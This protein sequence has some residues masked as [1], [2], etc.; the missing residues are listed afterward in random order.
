MK[1][2]ENIKN[3]RKALGMMQ[4]DVAELV[5][6]TQ[7]LICEIERG[8]KNPSFTVAE[9]IAELLHCSVED[10][11][12]GTDCMYIG[13]EIKRRRE[14]LGLSQKDLAVKTNIP[15]AAVARIENGQRVVPTKA[16]LAIADALHCTV[17]Q[18]LRGK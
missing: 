15:K 9:A 18:L 14:E 10:L 1:I 12:E 6:V 7:P 16:C 3:R 2:G 11:T 5:G 8:R 13:Q 4:V 17:D